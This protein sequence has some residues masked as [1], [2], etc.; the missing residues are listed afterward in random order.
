[1]KKQTAF[2]KASDQRVADG[3]AEKP[4]HLFCAAH[5]CPNLWSTSDGHVCRWHAEAPKERW[6]EVTQQQQWDETEQARMRGQAQPYAEPL[7]RADKVAI[8]Q[9]LQRAIDR[10]RMEPV[11][12]RAWIKR[13]Q[14]KRNA[15]EPLSAA[16][17]HA[18]AQVEGAHAVLNAARGGA[19]VRG[20]AITAALVRTGDIPMP[21]D[22]SGRFDGIPFPEEA[23]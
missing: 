19:N 22:V 9:Q 3:V 1:M 16:Q 11:D 5:G 2:D 7:T 13:L 12:P 14:A 17:R 18:L 6:P 8:L 20:H 23:A 15:G 10:M 21:D 4:R